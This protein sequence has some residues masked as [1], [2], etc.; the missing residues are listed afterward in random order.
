MTPGPNGAGAPG[1]G[2]PSDGK[3]ALFSAAARKPGTLVVECSR[4]RG[5]TR[6]SYVEFGKRH[7]PYWAWTPWRRYS[8]YVTCPACGERA[9]VS[10]RWL[11]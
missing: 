2:S 3:R 11:E 10:P 7:L 9:W 1:A 4:C 5:R 6:V 8:R